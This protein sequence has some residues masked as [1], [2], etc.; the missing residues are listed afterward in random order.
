MT[1]DILKNI[2]KGIDNLEFPIWDCG[3]GVLITGG[4]KMIGIWSET[5]VALVFETICYSKDEN[6]IKNEAYCFTSSPHKQW[7]DNGDNIFFD[8]SR[9]E[10]SNNKSI[11]IN[12]FGQQKMMEIKSNGYPPEIQKKILYNICDFFPEEQLFPDPYKFISKFKISSDAIVL[13]QTTKWRHPLLEDVYK[14]GFNGL[15]K[16]NDIHEAVSA[17]QQKCLP[18]FRYK[19]NTHWTLQCSL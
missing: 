11:S 7:F 18:K 15:P 4:M 8:F 5:E 3:D 16:E 2:D 9:D 13:F 1:T 12:F 14:E 10:G 6:L 17:L 19:I